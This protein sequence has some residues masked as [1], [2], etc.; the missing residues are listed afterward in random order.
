MNSQVKFNDFSIQSI[1][2]FRKHCLTSYFFLS[3]V[4]NQNCKFPHFPKCLLH[5]SD[6]LL[7]LKKI[8]FYRNFKWRQI[9]FSLYAIPK[10]WDIASFKKILHQLFL[11]MIHSDNHTSFSLIIQLFRCQFCFLQ[12]I[13]KSLFP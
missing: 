11:I 2:Q 3:L 12:N 8:F 1:R 7:K 10:H 13:F 4:I 9:A 6:V 5:I